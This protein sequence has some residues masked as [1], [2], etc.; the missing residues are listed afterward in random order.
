MVSKTDYLLRCDVPWDATIHHTVL[1]YSDTLVGTA[2]LLK[3]SKT[4]PSNRMHDH[5]GRAL[6][7]QLGVMRPQ[8]IFCPS[9]TGVWSVHRHF[10]LVREHV[11]VE[12]RRVDCIHDVFRNILHLY[13]CT[14][15]RHDYDGLTCSHPSSF[16][17]SSRFHTILFEVALLG[18]CWR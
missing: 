17:S 15:T 1:Y 8:N 6:C 7:N 10:G 5:V 2:Y 14:A 12:H 9:C 11:Q 4:I 3:A 16:L 13:I 18:L